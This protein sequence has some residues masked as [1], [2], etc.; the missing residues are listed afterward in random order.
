M[1]KQRWFYSSNKNVSRMRSNSH[2]SWNGHVLS[3]HA[4]LRPFGSTLFEV[5]LPRDTYL[6]IV[7]RFMTQ[8]YCIRVVRV[9]FH[10]PHRGQA[11][12]AHITKH[13]CV[14][15]RHRAWKDLACSRW[16][17]PRA[18]FQVFAR[19]MGRH[20]GLWVLND[21]S[22]L[23]DWGELLEINQINIPLATLVKDEL[24]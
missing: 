21:V 3:Y 12:G 6:C 20:W 24:E 16:L 17:A 14:F 8:L 18:Q 13:W 15:M 9:F 1:I 4:G 11:S 5:S 23:V 7:A 22:S 19:R 10:C 2:A